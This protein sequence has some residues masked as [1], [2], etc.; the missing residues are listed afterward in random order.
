MTETF[1]LPIGKWLEVNCKANIK[2][3]RMGIPWKILF[4]M[5]V[6]RLWLHGNNFIF[7]TG[8]VDRSCFKKSIKDSIEFFSVGLNAKIHKAKSCC[9]LGETSSGMGKA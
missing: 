3:N 2:Y 4:P 5:G 7:K 6:W 1:N 8:K 9:G